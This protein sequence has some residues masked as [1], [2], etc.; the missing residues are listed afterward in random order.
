MTV[1]FLPDEENH[2]AV[3]GSIAPVGRLVVARP[4]DLLD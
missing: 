1:S 3:K 2:R 4:E